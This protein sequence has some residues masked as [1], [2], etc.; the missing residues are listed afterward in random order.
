MSGGDPRAGGGAGQ[1]LAEAVVLQ[2]ELF[3]DLA[4]GGVRCAGGGEGLL[5]IQGCLLLVLLAAASVPQLLSL[6]PGGAP[7]G[8]Q[9]LLLL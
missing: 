8:R 2:A 4:G 1:V 7:G 3:L 9:L 5:Q 6:L